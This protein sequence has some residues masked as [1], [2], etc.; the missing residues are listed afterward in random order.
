MYKLLILVLFLMSSYVRGQIVTND[1]YLKSLDDS[2]A[3]GSEVFAAEL[4]FKKSD[5]NVKKDSNSLLVYSAQHDSLICVAIFNEKDKITSFS[6]HKDF[7]L[8]DPLP[9]LGSRFK[10][11]L[12]LKYDK[13]GVSGD[14]GNNI[15]IYDS[16]NEYGI[17]IILIFEPKQGVNVIM[18]EYEPEKLLEELKKSRLSSYF[19]SC[20]DF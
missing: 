7:N 11:E 15:F 5:Y 17:D 16:K 1:F 8:E 19:I 3:V 14:L 10:E 4:F 20:N 13:V 6:V 9:R 12:L 2:V 18:Y